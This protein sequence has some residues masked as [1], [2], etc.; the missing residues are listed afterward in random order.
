ML[1]FLKFIGLFNF[2]KKNKTIDMNRVQKILIIHPQ[3]VGDLIVA[4]PL[5]AEIKKNYP[6]VEI[7]ALITRSNEQ[8]LKNNP[9]VEKLFFY[10]EG[11]TNS[12]EYAELINLL[13]QEKFDLVI[14][15]QNTFFT[16]QRVT[17]PYRTGARYRIGFMRWGYRG[18]INTHEIDINNNWDNKHPLLALNSLN[19]KIDEIKY[20]IFLS[21]EDEDHVSRLLKEAGIEK[22]QYIIINPGNYS[23]FKT[24]PGDSYAEVADFLINNYKCKIIFT[25]IKNEYNFSEGIIKIMKNKAVNFVGKTDLITYCALI[26][27]AKLVITP[28][29]SAVHIASAFN[30]PT[31]AF[32]GISYRAGWFPLNNNQTVLSRFNECKLCNYDDK[33]IISNYI[34]YR[35][36]FFCIRGIPPASVIEEISKLLSVSN[37]KPE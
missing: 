34:C 36:D 26:K 30:V 24:W 16:W 21:K 27:H 17:I 28:D 10:E 33:E 13:K 6:Y 35:K 37:K 18:F 1:N 29:S 9:H 8:L 5:F 2:N 25:G 23:D 7:F 15:L 31:I 4:T 11:K 3:R 19:I 22:D 14:D 32:Y 12:K 20:D